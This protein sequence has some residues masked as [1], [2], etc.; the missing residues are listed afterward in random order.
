R[1]E[2]VKALSNPGSIIGVDN[3]RI[4][5]RLAASWDVAG[6]GEHVVHLSYG[7]YSGRYNEA[8]IGANSP[9]GN[10]SDIFSLYQGPAGQGVGFAPGFNVANYPV[11]SDN[12]S[13]TVPTANIF[14]DPN[15]KSPLVHEIQTSYGA[16]IHNGIGYAEAAFVWRKTTSMIEDIIDR[17]T[18]TTHVVL[19]GI[20]AG[21]VTNQLYENSDI[22]ERMYS[23]LAFTGRYNATRR[24]V[25]NGE[26]TV[27]LKNEGNYTGE[28]TNTPGSTSRIGDYP[29]AYAPE[30]NRFYPTGN[31]PSFERNRV[32][33]WAIYTQPMER[34][35]TLSFSGLLRVESAQTYSLAQTN[36]ALTTIQRNI[37]AAAGYP[38]APGRSTLYFDN[39]GSQFFAGY[40]AVDLDISYDIPIVGSVKPWVKFDVY[41]LFNNDKLIQWN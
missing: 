23:A 19:N 2:H 29:E 17:T 5:P 9:V 18:G 36:V 37:L 16:N 24:L 35:G 40:G 3:N 27:E 28:G 21:I 22:P 12:S 20:D 10:P 1:Y 6:N 33:A 15:T 26:W 7:Q 30:A 8:L 4:V 31:L 39:R 32:R 38:D 13:V 14:M 34:F 11:R 41:N 25:M